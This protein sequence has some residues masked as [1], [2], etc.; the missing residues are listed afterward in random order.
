MLSSGKVSLKSR[1][2]FA[3]EMI[4]KGHFVYQDSD[5]TITVKYLEAIACLRY[6]L[7]FTA[8][9]LSEYHQTSGDFEALQS[10]SEETGILDRLFDEVKHVCLNSIHGQPH[11]FFI[12]YIARQFGM[13]FLKRLVDHPA[14]NWLIPDHLQPSK[15]V[16][17]QIYIT[18]IFLLVYRKVQLL[19]H[20]SCM[21][22]IIRM[23][24]K[25][26]H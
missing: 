15:K 13:Q 22:S 16:N 4:R 19:T 23:S 21:E 20:I 26:L 3:L 2:E 1:V 24:V 11:E 12:K 8:N 25:L 7:S 14:F 17:V 10:P 18:P 6:G 9:C 5:G